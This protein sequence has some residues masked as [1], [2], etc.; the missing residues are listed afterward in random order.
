MFKQKI[1][2]DSDPGHDD[3]IAILLASYSERLDLIGVTTCSGNQ[4][5]EKT[6]RNALNLLNYFDRYDVPIAKGHPTP[7]KREPRICAEIHGET[8]LDGFIFPK[9]EDRFEKE[10]ACVFLINKLL[11]NNDVVVV[12]TG[13][14]T[15]LGLAIRKNPEIK[16]HIKEIVFMGGSTNEGNI[17]K[18]AE[19]N[20]LVDPE[21]ADICVNSGIPLRMLGLNVTRKILVREEIIK[22]AEKISTKGSELFVKL[23]KVFNKNQH[24]FFGLEAGPLHDPATIAALLDSSAFKWEKMNVKVDTSFTEEAGRTLCLEKEP[25]NVMVAVDVDLE[26]YWRII[27]EHLR[28]CI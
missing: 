14:M 4:T 20:I 24:D 25:K 21:A 10:E 23:M 27:F 16:S 9:Y 22:K 8:G 2:L 26:K 1:L 13:P 11:E 17:T 3:A 7:I 15:N 5:I 6:S 28:K 19:F 18:A 12:T